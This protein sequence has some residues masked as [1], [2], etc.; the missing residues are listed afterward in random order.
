MAMVWRWY[1]Y[2]MA[3]LWLWY[4]Y[5]MAML[6]LWYGDA[7]Y[8]YGMAMLWLTRRRGDGDARLGE[9]RLAG[10]GGSA[11][12]GASE[13]HDERRVGHDAVSVLVAV[14]AHGRRA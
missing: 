4:G 5:G 13:I 11:A 10:G 2:G 7:I 3:M 1:G 8:S 14:L 6:W 12:G 9:D